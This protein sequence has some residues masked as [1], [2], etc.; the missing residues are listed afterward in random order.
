MKNIKKIM[1]LV[2]IVSLFSVSFAEEMNMPMMDA[3]PMTST[4]QNSPVVTPATT[5]NADKV[6]PAQ[7]A[8][9]NAKVKKPEAKK[10]V[11]KIKKAPEKKAKTTTKKQ[12]RE[13][14]NSK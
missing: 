10:T 7:E 13:K 4:N 14:L 3:T 2:G 11:K 6:V 9:G 8:A 1:M 12:L 5:D